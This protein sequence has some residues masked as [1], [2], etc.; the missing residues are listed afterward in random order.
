MNRNT[1]ARTLTRLSASTCFLMFFLGCAGLTGPAVR[2]FRPGDIIEVGSGKSVS[3]DELMKK[4]ASFRVVFVGEVHTNPYDH[5]VQLRVIRG[6]HDRGEKVAVAMEMFP[7]RLQPVLDQWSAGE[8]DEDAFI[9]L[10]S[11][12]EVWGYPFDLYRGILTFARDEHL[13]VI[14]LNA[15]REIVRKVAKDGIAS[16]DEAERARIAHDIPMND[17][18]HRAM[19]KERF[20]EHPPT[21][22]DFEKFYEAQS[23]WDETMAETLADCFS[24]GTRTFDVAVVLAGAGHILE[25]HGVPADFHRRTKLGFVTIL[26]AEAEDASELI[27]QRAAD[28]LWVTP[29]EPVMPPRPMIGVILDP[30]A[31]AKGEN[32]I[33]RVLRGTLADRLGLQPG[34]QIVSI[35][36]KPVH[37]ANDVWEGLQASPDGL[38]H[39]MEILREGGLNGYAFPLSVRNRE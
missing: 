30:E 3:F 18:T 8:L 2:S 36:G 14:A 35:N 29:K 24:T 19:I 25:G 12:H 34:D 21:E 9:R 13:P 11:W 26:P 20:A 10:S 5:D 16:L 15:P 6:L 17:E 31:L 33:R 27:D 23:V 7:R 32:V 38:H 37:G 39:S 1:S 22:G 28:Y 4:T